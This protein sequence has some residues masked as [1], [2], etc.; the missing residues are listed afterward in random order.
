MR[1][2]ERQADGTQ[3]VLEF[4]GPATGKGSENPANWR[5]V[6]VIGK[7]EV[8]G[9][10]IKVAGESAARAIIKDD[11]RGV[12]LTIGG[13]NHGMP[14]AAARDLLDVLTQAIAEAAGA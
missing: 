8:I 9:S 5:E 1:K 2:V 12:H 14:L 10:Q 7:D 3:R 13:V 11:V 4:T 6:L